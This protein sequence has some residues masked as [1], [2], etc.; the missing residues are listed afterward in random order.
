MSPA[1][2]RRI[3]TSLGVNWDVHLTR[4]LEPGRKAS[5]VLRRPCTP[6]HPT[7]SA[8]HRRDFVGTPGSAASP[9]PTPRN[10][11]PNPPRFRGDPGSARARSRIANTLLHV[12][13]GSLHLGHL[14]TESLV[15]VSGRAPSAFGSLRDPPEH[16]WPLPES[17]ARLSPLATRTGDHK[18]ESCDESASSRC[19][20]GRGRH[21]APGRRVRRRRVQLGQLGLLE[22]LQG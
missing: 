7:K 3:R 10:P 16:L 13:G 14:A 9:S 1:W 22:D 6:S 11:H 5:P 20:P 18:G 15:E 12:L 17:S 21:P 4:S 19:G 8:P 2:I